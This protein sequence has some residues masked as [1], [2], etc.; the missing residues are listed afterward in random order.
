MSNPAEAAEKQ[1]TTPKY[2]W[3]IL[4]VVFFLSIIIPMQW[5]SCPPLKMNIFTV[6]GLEGPARASFGLLMSY[7][8]TTALIAALVAGPLANKIGHKIVLLIASLCL[9][10]GCATA[11]L[12]GSNFDV[13][14]V[15]RV[16]T[17]AG[18]GLAAVTASSVIAIWFPGKTRATAMAIWSTWV[19]VGMLIVYNAGPVIANAGGLHMVWWC[20]FGLAIVATIL[21]AVFYRQP[22]QDEAEISVKKSSFREAI[23]FLKSRQ[24]VALGIAWLGFNYVNYCFTTYNVDFF[25]TGMGMDQT[26]AALIGSI[27]SACGIIAPLFGA[28]SDRINKNKKYLMIVMGCL[29]LLLAGLFG[30]ENST[31]FFWIYLIFQILGNAILVATC[32]PMAPMLV[33][34]GGATAVTYALAVITVLQYLGQMFV[35]LCGTA[36]DT[37]G[38]TSMAAWTAVAPVAAVCFIASFFIRPSKPNEAAPAPKAAEDTSASE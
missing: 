3:T 17:G 15:S 35:F 9:V 7:L 19:P 13:L 5:F 16:I 34:R 37:F 2:A 21:I 4:V 11:A 29:A 1:L 38:Y 6:Y 8:S 28:I 30:F 32:R 23:P 18:V 33:G 10:V 26:M 31:L 25:Q 12:S 14:L 36:I 24:L 22:R 20:I 27:A